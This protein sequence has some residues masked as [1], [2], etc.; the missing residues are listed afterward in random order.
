A[1][2][3]ELSLWLH[4]VQTFWNGM[5]DQLEKSTV[6]K[7]PNTSIEELE[8]KLDFMVESTIDSRN[9]IGNLSPA[10]TISIE[11]FS[12]LNGL[13]GRKMQAQF[14]AH[15]PKTMHNEA[16]NLVEYCCFSFLAREDSDIHSSL[17]DCA[18]RRLMFVTMLAWQNP[19]H[20]DVKSA[21]N[22]SKNSSL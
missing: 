21:G 22:T 16:R 19:Y 2:K 7:I 18:F 1:V 5:T 12:R 6:K 14:E 4:R 8:M 10:A 11:Q 9:F 13:T 17:K 3:D 20:K 15:A